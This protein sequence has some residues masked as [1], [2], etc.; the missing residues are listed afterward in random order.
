M[1]YHAGL[2]HHDAATGE[3]HEIR[4]AANI[5]AGGELRIFFRVDLYHYGFAGHV[6]SGARNFWSSGAAWAAPI[7]PEIHE[8]RNGRVLNDFIEL[9]IVDREWFRDGRQRRFTSSATAGAGEIL[10]G[11]AILLAAIGASANDRHTNLRHIELALKIR[12][13]RFVKGHGSK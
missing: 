6:S 8:Y 7:S 12:C 13:K 2:L 3:D 9:H 11:D 4:D 1:A 5:V 10:G